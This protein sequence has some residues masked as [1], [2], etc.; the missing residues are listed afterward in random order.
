MILGSSGN[1]IALVALSAAMAAVAQT[2][3]P[4]KDQEFYELRIYRVETAEKQ[5]RVEAYLKDALLPALNRQGL[6]RIGVFKAMDKPEELSVFVLI[7]YS[8][9]ELIAQVNPKLAA[10][11]AY[12]AAAAGYM[13]SPKSDPVFQRLESRL[14]KAFSGIPVIDLPAQTAQG[15]PR[16]FELRLYESHNEEMA[17]RKVEMFNAGE[18][19]VMRDTGLAPVF[20]GEALIGQD[21][22]H[23]L[24]LLSAADMDAHKTHWQAFLSHPEWLRLK[25]LPRYQD[26]VSKIRNWF[27]TPT[28]YSQI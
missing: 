20:F 17:V 22:P 26:S 11:Q 10:D 13:A 27:L 24:Y 1:G 4:G 25:A 3:T 14:Y 16:I 7:P 18:T 12:Q 23:L 8:R 6:D 15:Q 9:L 19:Q 2:P 21:V 28:A 5:Q